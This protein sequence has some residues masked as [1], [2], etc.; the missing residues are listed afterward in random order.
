MQTSIRSTAKS[1]N[2]HKDTKPWPVEDIVALI[3]SWIGKICSCHT[4]LHSSAEL[5]QYRDFLSLDKL[6]K[7]G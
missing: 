1:T 2:T 5:N 7:I 3:N 6:D 4:D